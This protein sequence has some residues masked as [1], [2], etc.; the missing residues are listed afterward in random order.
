M[1]WQ[2]HRPLNFYCFKCSNKQSCFVFDFLSF[3]VP[4]S[5]I[6]LRLYFT[7]FV[8]FPNFLPFSVVGI[9]ASSIVVLM[10]VFGCKGD[11]L[12]LKF[13]LKIANRTQSMK[14]LLRMFASSCQMRN[15]MLRCHFPSWEEIKNM[16]CLSALGVRF[17]YISM[18]IESDQRYDCLSLLMKS[19]SESRHNGETHFSSSHSV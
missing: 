4:S 2:K 12:V 7:L 1:K 18:K 14:W 5:L 6:H 11:K 15:M 19:A 17:A 8:I 9:H 16:V 3:D 10:V 13:A